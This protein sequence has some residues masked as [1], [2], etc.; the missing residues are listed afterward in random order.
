MPRVL[1]LAALLVAAVLAVRALIAAFNRLDREKR[2]RLGRSALALVTRQDFG[3]DAKR[4]LAWWAENKE[5]HRLEWLIDSLM[6]EQ[7]AVRAAAGE[8]LKAITKEFFGYH[9]DLPRRERERAQARY[10]EWWA[11][12]GRVKHSRA[13]TRGG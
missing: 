12:V 3:T 6:H 11:S 2:R 13:A 9:D 1:L 10:R 5:R 7:A 4:W 8:E